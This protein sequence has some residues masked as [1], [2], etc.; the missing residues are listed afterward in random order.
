MVE[1]FEVQDQLMHM[2]FEPDRVFKIFFSMKKYDQVIKKTK[3]GKFS[4]FLEDLPNSQQ[5]CA[6]FNDCFKMYN[7][8]N[9]D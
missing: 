4:Q 6:D 1:P 2:V 8:R 3:S 7:I 5:I 9:C